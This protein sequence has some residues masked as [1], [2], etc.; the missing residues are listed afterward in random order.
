MQK[1]FKKKAIKKKTN[2]GNKQ[3]INNKTNDMKFII[4]ER[5]FYFFH[6]KNGFIEGELKNNNF[7]GYIE[8]HYKNGDVFKGE[9]KNGKKNGFGIFY[10]TFYQF[11]EN[12]KKIWEK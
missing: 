11:W 5:E 10:K 3:I 7:N 9:M 1:F 4:K 12:D 8:I 2:R 6:I